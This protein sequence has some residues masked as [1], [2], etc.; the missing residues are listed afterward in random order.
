MSK[1]GRTPRDQRGKEA[2]FVTAQS[3]ESEHKKRI[4]KVRKHKS[5][6]KRG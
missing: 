3:L 5:E 4:L 2:R 1:K 6:V